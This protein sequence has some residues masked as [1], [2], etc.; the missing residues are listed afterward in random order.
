LPRSVES[1][2]NSECEGKRRKSQEEVNAMAV[3]D[4]V[5]P[6]EELKI[7]SAGGMG[8]TLV[9]FGEKPA[10][11]I[12]DMSYAFVDSSYPLGDSSVG[13][14]A[15]RQIQKLSAVA[16]EKK[17]PIFYSTSEWKKNAVER[18]L[19]KR[20]PEV[21]K[22]L[23]DPKAHQIVTELTPREDEPVVIKTA[24]SAFHGTDLL[25]MLIQCNA[26]TLILTGMVTSGCVYA[27]AVDGFSLGFRVII[28][29]EGVADR[30]RIGHKV[31]LFNFH[32]KYGDVLPMAEVLR[33]LESK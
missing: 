12:V 29:E 28:P 25:R 33:H 16:R 24:P 17:I 22:A 8:T 3:W 14:P 13:W 2:E 18:G 23:Q 15:V 19:W 6:K 5:I 26:D 11:V 1:R 4:D 30:S 27:T 20:S 10:L 31:A 7:F 32:M 9:G 21:N